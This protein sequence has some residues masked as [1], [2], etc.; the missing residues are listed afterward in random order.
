VGSA[1]DILALQKTAGNQAVGQ[2]LRAR[3]R[4]LYEVRGL[5]MEGLLASVRMYRIMAERSVP[6]FGLAR[7]RAAAGDWEAV[8]RDRLTDF[9]KRVDDAFAAGRPTAAAREQ[10]DARLRLIEQGLGYL[11]LRIATVRASEAAIKDKL[12]PESIKRLAYYAER[13]LMGLEATLYHQWRN[14][15]VNA[16][17]VED[18][19]K[20][21]EKEI[22]AAQKELEAV[23]AAAKKAGELWE[24]IRIPLSFIEGLFIPWYGMVGMKAM[25]YGEFAV[26]NK[27]DLALAKE[28]GAV[29]FR[30]MG[31]LKERA[32]TLYA[33]VLGSAL[34][35]VL[36]ESLKQAPKGIGAED[37][38]FLVGRI[39]QALLK[40]EEVGLKTFLFVAAKC[41]GLL[42]LLRLPT[43]ALKGAAEKAKEA[44][45]KQL[46][47]L[48]KEL[49]PKLKEL[50]ADLDP[51]LILA[52]AR[53][54]LKPEAQK[55][56]EDVARS[57]EEFFEPLFRLQQALRVAGFSA[58]TIPDP[59]KIMEGVK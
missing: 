17:L 10:L 51:A 26:E 5:E 4:A 6:E 58:T 49:E 55:A 40:P 38:A 53:E 41:I 13:M 19:E 44:K 22:G 15:P 37:I 48:V 54:L 46:E 50:R 31:D 47:E 52:I 42:A 43:F 57:S 34:K 36:W 33:Q 29:W 45:E 24:T 16:K 7:F 56:L 32:P 14:D 25:E 18:M 8:L 12:P 30:A 35:G 1:S 23:R 3:D 59:A 27:E 28:R 39:I 20:F 9:R 21:A 11:H 2:L